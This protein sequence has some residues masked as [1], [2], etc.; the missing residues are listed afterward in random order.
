MEDEGKRD[1]VSVARISCFMGV[2]AHRVSG[3]LN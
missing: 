1:T 3:V 2:S